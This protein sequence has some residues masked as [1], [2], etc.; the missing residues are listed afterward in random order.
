[1]TTALP[2][3]VKEMQA[4]GWDEADVILFTGD[5]YIDHPAFGSA[6]IGRLLE[7]MG[8]RVA[9]VPQPNWR[10]DL[11]DFRKMGRPHLFFGVTAG[12]MDSM[13]NHYT[14]GKRLRSDDAY[15]PGGNSGARP[16]Y[17]TVVYTHILKKLFPDVPVILGG[18]EAS[19]RRVVHY[20]YWQN[21]LLPPI[22]EQTSADLL[23]YGMGEVPLQMVADQLRQGTPLAAIT[24]VPQTAYIHRENELPAKARNYIKLTSLAECVRDKKNYARNFVHIETESNRMEGNGLVQK[25]PGGWLIVH[26]AC[27]PM[28][29]E[30]IDQSFD[31]PYTRQPHPR[32]EGKP[33]IPAYD[34]IKH[35][36][37]IH[38]GCFGGCSF[39][40]ISAHQGKFVS[41]RSEQSVLRELKE[42]TRLPGFKG[43]VTDLGG[44][45]ANMYQMKG[46]DLE[47][48]RICKRP[49]CVYPTIC[50]NLDTDHSALNQLYNKAG[51]IEGIKK[52]TIGSGLRYDLFMA[53]S[54]PRAGKPEQEYA[55]NLIKN[56]VSG[57]LKV[58]PEHTDPQTL[59][60]MR[61][62]SFELFSEFHRYFE[63]V[64]RQEG[65]QQ[66]LIPYFIS[67]HPGTTHQAMEGLGKRMR[68]MGYHLEQVQMFTPSPMTLATVM[69]FTGFD[70]YTLRPVEVAKDTD[71]R[72]SQHR[73][74]FED[75]TPTPRSPN[76][77]RKSR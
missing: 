77:G 45:S 22:L 49:S 61:K 28:T 62:P 2:T 3:S 70:P 15:T 48:C 34:M 1:M 36:V 14:A 69:Y 44:P 76:R 21:R 53:Q 58:A 6:V 32:Y 17:P 11:R 29:T 66:Q 9:I 46:K 8:L 52:I 20:D 65:L 75:K 5:A 12:A 68:S 24:D 27:P 30:Q 19:L 56:H 4:R 10:D 38:R 47:T 60:I 35:S 25:V 41:S 31:L 16:D 26:G 18:I 13:I 73:K 71:S 33:P 54:N 7:S 23:I 40:T 51:A 39:C 67:A 50:P 42:I 64:N 63:R 55:R 59:Q 57:R 37:N 74:F 43:H 72:S